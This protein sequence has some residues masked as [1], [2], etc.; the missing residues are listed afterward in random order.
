M[1]KLL[2]TLFVTTESAYI[3]LDGENIV[4]TKAKEE[5]GRFPLHILQGIVSFSYAGASPALMGACAERNIGLAFCTPRG[6]FLARV[7]NQ[8]NGNVILRKTQYLIS[9]DLEKSCKIAKMMIIGKLFNSK[10][11]IERTIRDN[12]MRVDIEKLKDV[13]TKLK[14]SCSAIYDVTNLDT[15]RGIEGNLANQYFSVFD[16]MIL[17]SDKETF[18]FQARNRRPPLDPCNALLS[19]SYSLL[20]NDCASALESVGLDSYVGFM[21]KDKSGRESLSLDLMEELR[22]CLADRFVLSLINNRIVSKEDFDYLESGAV[23]LN[24]NGRKKF[25]KKWQDKK[26][27]ELTHPYL[28]EKVQ[29]GMIPY[30]QSLLLA[31]Y[32]RND[33]DEYPPFLWK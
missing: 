14:Q 20:A 15:L 11:S 32:I 18:Y 23:I 8:N 31:R 16:E 12:Q 24:E 19:F 29:W 3:S 10:Q 9:E 26:Q 1:K 17:N 27:D 28:K 7:A 33:L 21:H 22:P 2:N 6:R 5:I 13:S 25:L 30:I 4:I